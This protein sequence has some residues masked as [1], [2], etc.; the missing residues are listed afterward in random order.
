MGA[1]EPGS[2]LQ[3]LSIDRR[4]PGA[5]DV[6]IDIAFC[7]ICH[8]DLHHVDDD[9]G[10]SKYPLVP[11][12]EI[13]GTVSAVGSDVERFAV[14]DVVGVGCMIGS[15]GACDACRR[16]LEQFC[17]QGD[18][19]T[20]NGTDRD[21]SPTAGGYSRR[22]VV[23]ADFV[24]RVPPAIPLECAAPLLCAGITMYSPLRHWKVGPGR[25]VAFLGMGGVGHVGVKIARALGAHTTVLDVTEDKREDSLRLG[26]DDFRVTAVDGWTSGI[27]RTFDL[28][29]C[30]VPASIDIDLYLDLLA[31]DGTLVLIGVPNRPLEVS[32]ISLIFNRR[33]IAGS[34]IGGVAETQEMLDFCAQHGIGAEVEVIGAGDLDVAYER[35]RAGDV[36][37]RFV[38]D[39]ATIPPSDGSQLP[40][41][42]RLREEF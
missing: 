10:R 39:C 18:I 28:I 30:T 29:I 9:Y 5:R 35:V 33:S 4:R 11:G 12:H 36:K 26:A 21:G 31:T 40:P 6:Q 16:G 20:A 15:C 24:L 34:L 2:R 7:G 27:Q 42:I 19:K 1:L 23:S 3:A 8:S 41:A 32:A 25:R 37:F 14:G 13:V 17:R 22:I 38:L